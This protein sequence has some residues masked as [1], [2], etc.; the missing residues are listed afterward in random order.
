MS[1]QPSDLSAWEKA[2]EEAPGN[3][4]GLLIGCVGLLLLLVLSVVVFLLISP[5]PRGFGA[6]LAVA[7]RG[8]PDVVGANYWLTT[9]GPPTLRVYLA[10][11]V[12][13]PRAREI[14]CGLVRDELGRAGI[15][16]TSW[17]VI[18]ATGESLAT[19]STICP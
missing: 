12:R 6:A 16:D 13:Q 2:T 4:R 17:T 9:S 15:S 5:L 11:G 14:G 3:R 7:D 1:E 8:K 19:S 10:P 18:A